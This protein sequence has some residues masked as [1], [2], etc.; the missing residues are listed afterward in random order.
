M[1]QVLS[2]ME[3]KGEAYHVEVFEMEFDLREGEGAPK[4][5]ARG[6]EERSPKMYYPPTRM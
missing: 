5:T 1:D 4:L 6:W 2:E 3:R